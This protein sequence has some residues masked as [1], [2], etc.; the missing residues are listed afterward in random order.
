MM[1]PAESKRG[2]S[3]CQEQT[4]FGSDRHLLYGQAAKAI[5]TER[6]DIIVARPQ[7]QQ[8]LLIILWSVNKQPGS[9][10]SPMTKFHNFSKT[11]KDHENIFQS[12][13]LVCTGSDLD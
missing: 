11:F 9:Y 12:F 8:A 10:I 3:S 4:V 2:S 1:V 5:K 13:I 7:V 6:G